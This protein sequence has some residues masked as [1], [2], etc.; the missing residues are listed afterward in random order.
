MLPTITQILPIARGFDKIF[1]IILAGGGGASW[2]A[3]PAARLGT[4]EI[5]QL[6]P[7]ARGFEKIFEIILA[8]GGGAS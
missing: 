2:G 1:E 8:G 4:R 6:L 5:T 3:F 7:I